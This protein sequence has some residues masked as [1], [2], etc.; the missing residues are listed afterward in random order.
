M[1]NQSGWTLD[2]SGLSSH[3]KKDWKV[4]SELFELRAGF[5]RNE[6]CVWIG[7]ELNLILVYG[8]MRIEIFVRTCFVFI[9]IRCRDWKLV[10]KVGFELVLDWLRLKLMLVH[11]LKR[12]ETCSS[13]GSDS[14]GLE[15]GWKWIEIKVQIYVWFNR[16]RRND[17][18]WHKSLFG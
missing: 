8:L 14:I 10:L 13:S 7:F 6:R 2:S 4:V 18:K 9:L 1:K 17:C 5:K 3:V 11:G 16:I 12:I 15:V